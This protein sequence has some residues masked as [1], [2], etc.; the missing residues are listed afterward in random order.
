MRNL[1]ELFE[2]LPADTACWRILARELRIRF[3]K[4][5]QLAVKLIV[6]AVANGGCRFFVVAAIVLN[7]FTSQRFNTHARF[8]FGHT[9]IIRMRIRETMA[10][11][12][13]EHRPAACAPGGHSCPL[14][15]PNQWRKTHP[16]QTDLEVYVRPNRAARFSRD[17][18]L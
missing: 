17:V 11:T 7:D 8:R 18:N 12:L 10:Q 13:L 16:G 2:R 14:L 15:E 1:R 9:L 5:R 6:F 4:L 3:L